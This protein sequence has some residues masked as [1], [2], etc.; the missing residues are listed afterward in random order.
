M[1]TKWLARV[2]RYR[3]DAPRAPGRETLDDW[4]RAGYDQQRRGELAEAEQTY[5]RV[6]DHDPGDADALFFLGMIAMGDGRETRAAELFERAIGARPNDP[7]FWFALGAV[8]YPLRRLQQGAE[9]CRTGIT[10]QPENADMWNNLAT[11][12]VEGGRT[13]EAREIMEQLIASGR[14]LGQA[15]FNL[16]GIYRDYARID[17]AVAACRRAVGLDPDNPDAYTN[18]LLTLNYSPDCDA[19]A[20]LLEHRRFGARFA[21]PYVEPQP[22]RSW[23]RRLRVGYVSPDF[24]RHVVAQFVEPILAHHDRERFEIF[25]YHNQRHEDEYTRRFRQLADH[26]LDCVHMSDHDLAE[27]I[28]SDGVDMLVDLAGHTNG[29]RLRVFAAKPAPL[30]LSYLGYPNTTGLAAI[31]YRITDGRA[32]PAGEAEQWSVE[33]LLRPWPTYFCYRPPLETPDVA[34]LPASATGCVTFGS[35]NNFPKVSGPF[36]DAAAR[37]LAM[38]PGSRLKLKSKTLAVP[39]V[40]QRVRERFAQAGIDPARLELRGWESSVHGHLAAYGSIDIAID[41]FPYNGATTTC[42]ALW[43][44][45]PVVTVVGDR[46]AGRV[47]ASLL[48]AVGLGELVAKDVDAYVA[49]CASLAADLG[50]LARLRSGLRERMRQSPL[51]DETGFTRALERCYDEIWERKIQPEAGGPALSDEAIADELRRAA[52]LRAAR[53]TSEAEAAYQAILLKR[54]DQADALT[55]LWDFS[56][57]TGNHGAAVDWLRK[58]IAANGGAPMLHY[59]MGCSLL[60]QGNAGDAAASFQHALTLD[61]SMA[62]A[63]NN[64]G[65]ALEAMGNLTEARDCYRR[66]ADL[67]PT[68][69]DALYNLGNVFRQIGD[70]TRAVEYIRQALD[71]DPGRADWHC[72]MGDLLCHRRQLDEAVQSYGRAVALEREYARAYSGRALAFQ[73]LGLAGEAEADFRKAMELQPNNAVTHSNWLQWLHFR[74]GNEAQALFEAHVAWAKRHASAIG[75]QAARAEHERYLKRRLNIGYVSPDFKRDAMAPFI[76]PVLATHDR[77]R[78][79]VFCYS[80]VAFPD[81]VTQRL[82]GLCEEWRDISAMPDPWVAQQMRADRIDVLVDLAGHTGGGRML[83][84]AGKPAPVLASWLGYPDTTGLAAMDHRLTDAIVDPDGQTERFH[85]ENLVR[86]PDGFLCY[87]APDESPEVGGLPLLHAGRVTFGSFNNLA[88]VTPSMIALWAQILHALPEARLVLKAPGLAAQSARQALCR[89]FSD[90]GIPGERLELCGPEESYSRH[91]EKYNGIDIA[92]DVFP[93]NGVTTTCEALWMGVPVVT[94]S[95]GTPVSRV[96]AS[97]LTR[98]GLTDLVAETGDDYL[99]KALQLARDVERLRT[100]RNGMRERMRSSPL[101]NA[102]QFTAELEQAYGVMWDRWCEREEQSERALRLHVGG[103]Q[104]MPGWKILNVQ[105]GP[106]VEYVGDCTDLSRFAD[107]SVDEIYASHVLEHLGYIVDLPH[108]LAEFSRVLKKGG[109]ARI[110]VPDLE[111]LC[112]LFLDP[113]HT[114]DDRMHIMRMIFGGQTDPHD[115]HFVGLTFEFLSAYL[116][117]AGFERVERV[118]DFGLFEDASLIR[119][120]GVRIS[121]NVIAYK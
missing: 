102:G 23:P 117:K 39:H 50:G 32:D 3:P 52:E 89:Q 26:W 66:A 84:F 54:P 59:M 121:L 65:C 97:I 113:G 47:G 29:H 56:H 1:L 104:M 58:G 30:Q 61:P 33:R 111:V 76:E 43:M 6:L 83:L 57:E 114:A 53:K 27:R 7:A 81:E 22:D 108:A 112:R 79:K 70:M 95:G 85:C 46:H 44:G 73:E 24:R 67:D 71:R 109:A 107:G 88:K 116:S 72:N 77:K 93:Y 14:G 86:L 38:V 98:I 8:C 18:L 80:S 13:E 17:E 82:R 63:H 28:R 69:A 106:G 75:R 110:S 12:L 10:L 103:K 78:F 4:L 40:A 31:D 101:L 11:M 49:T 36:L 91:L 92:L 45:V 5:D 9:V 64:L 60:A 62:R 120:S 96:G 19:A 115:F 99:Q 100:L 2:L 119:F 35:F 94:L 20:L 41:T 37:I 48:N 16:G 21:R 34:P 90:H 51:M 118:T 87:R 55:A 25:C 15:Y 105:P 68:L 74:Q 42:E